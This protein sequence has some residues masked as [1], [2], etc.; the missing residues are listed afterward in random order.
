VARRR[1]IFYDRK[2]GL[3]ERMDTAV[4]AALELLAPYW[5]ALKWSAI[6]VRV[7]SS[8]VRRGWAAFRPVIGNAAVGGF[9]LG[10]LLDKG[11]ATRDLIY[12]SRAR[13]L[14]R[15]LWGSG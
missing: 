8:L 15:R 7:R 4:W 14:N 10:R 11:I 5:M 1:L 6:G 2:L 12:I 13:K 9:V 3:D